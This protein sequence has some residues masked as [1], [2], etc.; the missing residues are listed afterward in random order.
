MDISTVPLQSVTFCTIRIKIDVTFE[1]AKILKVLH[2]C[3]WNGGCQPWYDGQFL[4]GGRL[5][6]EK[7]DH[8]QICKNITKYE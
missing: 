6:P 3:L 7:L 1:V 5:L 8:V 4:H 2:I